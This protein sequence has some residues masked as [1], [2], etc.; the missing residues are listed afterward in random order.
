VQCPKQIVHLDDELRDD[1]G[2]TLTIDT[3]IERHALT[4][5]IPAV[6]PRAR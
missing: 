6:A 2:G 1:P 5:L 4:F 3:A